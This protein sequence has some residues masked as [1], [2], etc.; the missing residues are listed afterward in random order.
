MHCLNW[1]PEF[2]AELWVQ[3]LERL[4]SQEF[5]P[6]NAHDLHDRKLCEQQNDC[7]WTV[8]LCVFD[9]NM[10]RMCID[11]TT[12][13]RDACQACM[14]HEDMQETSCRK[15]CN[16]G[17]LLEELVTFHLENHNGTRM[18]FLKEWHDKHCPF[19]KPGGKTHDHEF[20]NLQTAL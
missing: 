7:L 1:K 3:K 8:L 15:R 14:Q 19:N 10:G 12:A 4:A 17:E 11:T 5:N 18:L 9:N 16:S 6:D 2:L 13:T 20:V